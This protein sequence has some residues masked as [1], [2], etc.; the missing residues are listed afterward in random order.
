MCHAKRRRVAVS[1]GALAVT[2]VTAAGAHAVEPER[3]FLSGRVPA[4]A[5]AELA[6]FPSSR[7]KLAAV[8]GELECNVID[9]EE[10]ANFTPI[11]LVQGP[12][13]V[14]F[15]SSWLALKDADFTG[16]PEDGNFANEPSPHT[17]AFF[18]EATDPINFSQGVQFVELFYT[19]RADSLPVILRAW[20]GLNGTGA[21][22]DEVVGNTIGSSLDGALCEGDPTGA[23]CL[24]ST[25]SLT[26]EV[27]NIR[28]ITISGAAANAFAFDDMTFCNTPPVELEV[29]PEQGFVPATVRPEAPRVIF[30]P[31]GGKAVV[32]FQ[33][34]AGGTVICVQFFDANGQPITQPLLVNQLPGDNQ[35]PTASFDKEGNL[36]ILWT[37]DEGVFALGGDR[38]GLAASQGSSVVGRRFDKNG[39]PQSGESTVSSGV[40]G[41]SAQPE[42]DS[43]NSGNT[44]VV[45][46][47][48]GKVRARLLDPNGN[49]RSAVFDVNSGNSGSD[50]TLAV[51]ASGDFVVAWQGVFQ[52]GPAIFVRRYRDD[53]VAKGNGE[54]VSSAG[55]PAHA[56]V[57]IDD[58]GNFIVAWDADGSS[59]RDIFTQRYA[60]NGNKR[61]G[62]RQ[63]NAN[64]SGDQTRPRVDV[65]AKGRFAVVWESTEGAPG[66]AASIQ[67]Q[68]VVGRVFNPQGEPER[69]E[70]EIAATEA[71]TSPEK[72][73]VSLDEKDDMTVVYERRG[74]GGQSEGIFR[75]DINVTLPPGTCV[76]D[77]TT[78]CLNDGRF[79]VTAL[80]EEPNTRQVSSGTAVSLTGDTG[81]F[82][83][84]NPDNVEVV[85]KALA[86]CPVNSRFWVFAAGLTNVEVT[87]RVDDVITGQSNT[88]FNERN[89]AYL[90]ILDSD[91]FATCD[92]ASAPVIALTAAEVAAVREEVLAGLLTLATGDRDEVRAAVPS[93][94]EG[95]ADASSTAD[96]TA[97]CTTDSD[98]LCLTSNR[99]L[100]EVG[101]RTQGGVSGSGQAIKLTND[102]G[103]FWFFDD[104]NVE[105]VIKVLNACSIPP[106]RFWVFAAG[107]TNVEATLTVRDTNTGAQRVYENPLGTAFL[108]IQDTN[109]F[110]TC[111]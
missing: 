56:A 78:L 94:T 75:K 42:S 86:A 89:E 83:F 21:R 69:A 54:V 81:F 68:S 104:D 70:Q 46:Q 51:S 77:D 72:P 13:D 93:A 33:L 12:I 7:S 59:G 27:N 102:T 107:L 73:D 24:W 60:A 52:N 47:D 53:G 16:N 25:L 80:W 36:L 37:R 84:F 95:A 32:W 82:W 91:A 1:V 64:S 85:V 11:G 55:S 39:Q 67:G 40:S 20:S 110:A 41:E 96:S 34:G 19:A 15:G 100:V 49:P 28:S 5:V 109:A 111:P 38:L 48:G 10:V 79:R 105:I 22:I 71:G 99:F 44:V 62:I 108:P 88:Y 18:L 43:D 31:D 17:V 29:G 63:A 74:A 97:A 2:F 35:T 90:P 6:D 92:A 58:A 106:G 61:G 87:L 76:A 66:N 30:G 26:S 45:W 101:F 50:P 4:R 8:D 103:Y 14:D 57:G 98:S 65:N 23:F 9:F 3:P